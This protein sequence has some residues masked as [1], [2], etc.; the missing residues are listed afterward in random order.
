MLKEIEAKVRAENDELKMLRQRLQEAHKKCKWE[1]VPTN[2]NDRMTK[3][4]YSYLLY[5]QYSL[6]SAFFFVV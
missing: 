2:N 3:V 5:I 6:L 4:R 1:D